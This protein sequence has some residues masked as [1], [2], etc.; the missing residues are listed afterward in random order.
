MGVLDGFKQGRSDVVG[1]NQKAV[2]E[3][4]D[5]SGRKFEN[6]GGGKIIRCTAADSGF[7]IKAMKDIAGAG[8]ISDAE[9][10]EYKDFQ[11]YRFEYENEFLFCPRALFLTQPELQTSTLRLLNLN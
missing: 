10:E 3:I 8:S 11:L 1:S 6:G 5:F 7:D 4:A 9:F 2:L